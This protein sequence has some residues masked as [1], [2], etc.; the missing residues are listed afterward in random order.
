[1]MEHPAI[2]RTLRTGYPEPTGERMADCGHEIYP[3]EHMYSWD[4]RYICPDC[5]LD[6]VTAMELDELAE[7][8][9]CE[10]LA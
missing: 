4:G 2:T 8:L 5:L 10:V 1:M 9:G 7:M 6:K 3:G